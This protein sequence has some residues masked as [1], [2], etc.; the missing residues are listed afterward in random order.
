MSMT[1]SFL[2]I[3]KEQF[4]LDENGNLLSAEGNLNKRSGF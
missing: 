4:T 2:V 1:N 3:D